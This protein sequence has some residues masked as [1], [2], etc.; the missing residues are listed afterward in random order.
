[1]KIFVLALA[2]AL[3]GC[4]TPPRFLAAMYNNNDPCQRQVMPDWCGAGSGTT[5]TTRDWRTGNYLTT[6]TVRRGDGKSY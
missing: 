4:A 3:T 1:M 2:V 6:T 5:L